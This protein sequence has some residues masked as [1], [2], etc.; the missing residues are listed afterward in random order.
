[1]NE[2]LLLKRRIHDLVLLVTQCSSCC[3]SLAV[4]R[5]LQVCV[6]PGNFKL[7]MLFHLL[8]WIL[9]IP[10]S[11]SNKI[12]SWIHPGSC[13]IHWLHL[14]GRVRQHL[15]IQLAHDAWGQDPGNLGL[16]ESGRIILNSNTL[17][18]LLLQLEGSINWL[19]MSNPKLDQQ[20]KKKQIPTHHT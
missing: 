3:Y 14:C 16:Q 11:M 19:V 12:P 13:R 4:P 17:L 10:L 9:F 2:I 5:L 18:W 20:N 8:G 1:M 7:K 15:P 6:D